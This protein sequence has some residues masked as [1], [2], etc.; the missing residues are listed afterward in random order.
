M[1]YHNLLSPIT[2][3]SLTLPNRVMMG[4]MH[5]GLE[6]EANG[7]SRLTAFYAKRAKEH[8][9]LIVTGGVAVCP[10]GSGSENFMSIYK[11]E[12]IT[13]WKPLTDKVHKAG[14]RIALQLFHAGR[15]SYKALTKLHPVAPSPIKSPINPDSPHELTSD[16]V[17][18]TISHFATGARRAKKAGFD[19]VEIMGSEGYLINQFFSPVTNVRN[20]KWGGSFENRNRFALE[21]VKAIREEVGSSYPVIFRMSGIDLIESSTT[22]EETI[23]IA[24]E[25]EKAGVDA[26]NIGIGWHESKVPTISMKV[27][28]LH[29][30]PVAAKIKEH[31]KIPVIASNRINNPVD[32][33]KVLEEKRADIVSMARP[34]LADPSFVT[35]TIENRPDEINTCI[36]CNQACLDH[37]FE[38]KFAS[39]L[40]NPEAGRELLF[41]NEMAVQRKN[42]LVIG[43]GPAGL[44]AA[45][46]AASRGHS[47]TI[48]DE[49]SSLGGQLLYASSVPGKQEF[50]ETI[51]YY[52]VQLDKLGVKQQL[53]YRIT[54]ED[55][56]LD[57]ADEVIVAVGIIPRTPDITGIH[58]DVLSYRDIFEGIIPKG[59]KIVIIGG[60]GIAC[61]L[62]L[63]LK[64]KGTYD[65]TLLQR[66]KSFAR[67]IGKTTRW[68]T[69]LELKQKGIQMIGNITYNQITTEGIHVTIDDKEQLV[70][71]DTII[72][73]SG[74]LPNEQLYKKLKERH[75][76][77]HLIGGAKDASGLD[78]KRAIYDG[79]LV[80]RQI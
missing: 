17:V 12:D 3:N 67:G 29:F 55:P 69:L 60:G 49:K 42:V 38:G 35:K 27:P 41:T 65:I 43:A 79:T 36:A 59:E 74:Q 63:F 37:I 8:V 40:V 71:A 53:N 31:I 73:A 20:D 26:L 47:V 2:I 44:E 21:I 57:Q 64:S 72:T 52:Q 22:E 1:A 50:K 46:S 23:L 16:Q 33:E 39:C 45:R 76:H 18:Q 28:R 32:A 58:A 75:S 68:A 15:Y 34:F 51:R 19:A 13:L 61:D 4:S 24:K 11:D 54:D 66:G 48:V 7:M 80:G 56:L 30:T 5:V 77:V 78:A 70:Q 62:S 14:G 25:L 6:S 10:E 9:G